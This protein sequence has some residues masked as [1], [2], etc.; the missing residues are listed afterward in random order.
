LHF[1]N[2]FF[3]HCIH[4]LLFLPLRFPFHICFP[5]QSNTKPPAAS[6]GPPPTRKA[7]TEHFSKI[8]KNSKTLVAGTGTGTVP[9]TP[10]TAVAK[11]TKTPASKATATKRK[12][13]TITS[14]SDSDE[15][16]PPT[17]TPAKRRKHI[18]ADDEGD[19]E[20]MQKE[21]ADLVVKVK[22]EPIDEDTP[23]KKPARRI[24]AG[25]MAKY[26]ESDAEEG[27]HPEDAENGSEDEY[28]D[29]EVG[30]KMSAYLESPDSEDEAEV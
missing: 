10:S 26:A 27:G 28:V 12:K 19:D 5:L 22:D 18:A 16:A 2:I 21:L 8:R 4:I 30:E 17:K 11:K 6:F 25:K 20:D 7:F 3:P 15:E 24:A 29:K 23:S 14:A 1:P 13:A 9:S